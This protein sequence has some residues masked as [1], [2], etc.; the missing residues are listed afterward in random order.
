M[1]GDDRPLLLGREVCI[2]E[3]H[4]LVNAEHGECPSDLAREKRLLFVRFGV[5]NDAPGE[6]YG[7]SVGA[8]TGGLKDRGWLGCVDS[9][10]FAVGLI[11]AALVGLRLCVVSLA[12]LALGD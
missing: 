11:L 3:N 4:N 10:F 7:E 8:A 5:G 12:L 6:S 9:M 1:L 2:V